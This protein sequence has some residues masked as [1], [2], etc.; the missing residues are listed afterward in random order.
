MKKNKRSKPKRKARGARINK[1]K[2]N[3][4]SRNRLYHLINFKENLKPTLR[5]LARRTH[6]KRNKRTNSFSVKTKIYSMILLKAQ[7]MVLKRKVANTIK[8]NKTRRRARSRRVKTNS[9][10][11]RRRKSKNQL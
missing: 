8:T 11:R 6:A 2:M 4:Q 3:L 5:A 9:R 10:S 1:L 7:T